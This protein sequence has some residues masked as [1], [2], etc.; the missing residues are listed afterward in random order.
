MARRVNKQQ[1]DSQEEE[2]KR[3]KERQ[4]RRRTNDPLLPF[5]NVMPVNRGC[6]ST[7]YVRVYRLRAARVAQAP[8]SRGS[9]VFL[10]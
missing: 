8:V 3:E 4:R 5:S 10:T 7:T 9:P 6:E 1:E 2:N